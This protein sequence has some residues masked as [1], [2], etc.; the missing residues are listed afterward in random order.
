[1]FGWLQRHRPGRTRHE[2]SIE[3]LRVEKSRTELADMRLG[4]RERELK[5]DAIR[6]VVDSET[7]PLTALEVVTVATHRGRLSPAVYQRRKPEQSPLELLAMGLLEKRLSASPMAELKEVLQERRMLEDA[8]D[9]LDG[10]RGRRRGGDDDYTGDTF[11]DVARALANSPLGEAIGNVLGAGAAQR[12]AASAAAAGAL[13][14]AADSGGAGPAGEALAGATPQAPAAIAGPRPVSFRCGMAIRTL[15]GMSPADGAR[16]VLH[17]ADQHEQLAELVSAFVAA[18]P[19]AVPTV[20]EA[21][22]AEAEANADQQVLEWL[23][24]VS[25]FRD[26]LAWTLEAH[27]HMRALMLDSAEDLADAQ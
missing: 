13:T 22:C 26:A 11:V 21:F 4:V 16:W 12:M 5:I 10:R 2:Q 24:L 7:D 6:R 20:L 18:E 19:A 23:P 17:Q 15:K 3:D 27:A 9:E 8:A 25:Y 14:P 1:M